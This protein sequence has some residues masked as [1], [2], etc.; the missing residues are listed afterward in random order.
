MNERDRAIISDLERFRCL[1]RDDIVDLHFKGIK[2]GVDR[3]NKVLKR[4]RRDGYIDCSTERRMYMYFP[5]PS[6]KKDSAKIAH[7]QAIA[8]F[9]KEASVIEKP[10][11]FIVE[12]KY[13]KGNPEPDVFMIWRRTPFYVE[14]QRSVYSNKVM[15]EKMNRY[16][17]YLNG[18]A[19]KQESWQ[20]IDKKIFPFVW[21]LS[22]TTYNIDTPFKVLQTRTVADL[23]R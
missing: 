12:P 15:T 20:P 11:I 7:F 2:N 22:E 23:G 3:A 19:W 17:R 13:G 1:Q 18:A 5:K 10:R 16:E 6:I 14:I 8:K 9:Y 21:I 4:L